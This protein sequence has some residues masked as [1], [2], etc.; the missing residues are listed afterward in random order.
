MQKVAETQKDEILVD[1]DHSSEKGGS[2]EAKGWLSKLTF[3]K[4][5]GLMGT[6]K[7]TNIGKSLI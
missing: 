7:W 2:T 3:K 5:I 1:S 4:G 6:I